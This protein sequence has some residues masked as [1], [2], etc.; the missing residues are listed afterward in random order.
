MIDNTLASKLSFKFDGNEKAYI[1]NSGNMW[2][3]GITFSSDSPVAMITMLSQGEVD[4]VKVWV[5]GGGSTPG[6]TFKGM[7]AGTGATGNYLQMDSYWNT[8]NLDT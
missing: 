4:N 1:D 5:Y 2:I 6:Y 8:K 7:F 3:N